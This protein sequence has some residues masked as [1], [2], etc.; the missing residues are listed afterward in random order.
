MIT[1]PRHTA[2]M[3]RETSTFVCELTTIANPPPR[4]APT[5]D[6]TALYATRCVRSS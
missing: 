6:S 3:R 1:T 2:I 5:A 4:T